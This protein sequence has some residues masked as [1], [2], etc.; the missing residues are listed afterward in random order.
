MAVEPVG[1]QPLGKGWPVRL[2]AGSAS[3]CSATTD[4]RSGQP[5]RTPTPV[6]RR[7]VPTSSGFASECP[8]SSDRGRSRSR[9]RRR[10]L[11]IGSGAHPAPPARRSALPP[12]AGAIPAVVARSSGSNP[13]PPAAAA[14][15]SRFRHRPSVIRPRA[16]ASSEAAGVAPAA[17]PR[18]L[19]RSRRSSRHQAVA[20]RP[21]TPP[22]RSRPS[23]GRSSEPRSRS[24]HQ[25]WEPLPRNGDCLGHSIGL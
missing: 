7:I 14:V 6:L 25:V 15:T 11:P 13:S 20:E 17:W 22:G 12:S 5:A 3:A 4:E 9:G 24:C 10:W 23:P 19:R 16:W 18:S 2:S 8:P 21:A 1:P